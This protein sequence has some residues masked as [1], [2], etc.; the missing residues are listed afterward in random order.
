VE[1]VAAV[2]RAHL[3]GRRVELPLAVR[4]DPLEAG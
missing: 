1:M 3:S 2:Y 4:T